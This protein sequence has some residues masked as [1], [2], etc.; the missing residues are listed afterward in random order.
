M[1]T[2]FIEIDASEVKDCFPRFYDKRGRFFEIIHTDSSGQDHPIGFVGIRPLRH[3][4]CEIEVF[5][6]RQH[7]NTLNKGIVL[8]VLDLPKSF[9]F[10]RCW[11]KTTR[12]TVI[13]LL[14][15][16]GKYGIMHLGLIHKKHVFLREF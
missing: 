8:A 4:S 14:N 7:R 11:M 5:V 13:K 10:K 2:H 15:S 3:K 1:N 9:D 16:M 6:F 12:K